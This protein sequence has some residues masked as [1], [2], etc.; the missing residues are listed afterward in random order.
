MLM[1]LEN[2]GAAYIQDRGVSR[3]GELSARFIVPTGEYE[4]VVRPVNNE[5]I[6]IILSSVVGF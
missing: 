6:S 3:W 4:N 1:L 5:I 2:K